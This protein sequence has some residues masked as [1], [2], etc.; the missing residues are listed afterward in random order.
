MLSDKKLL[1]GALSGVLSKISVGIVGF[2][3]IPLALGVLDKEEYGIWMILVSLTSWL[4]LSDFGVLNGIVNFWTT[5]FANKDVNEFQKYLKVGLQVTSGLM[6]LGILLTFLFV[7]NLNFYSIFKIKSLIINNDIRNA[8]YILLY[9]F[10][11]SLPL[12]VVPKIAYSSGN[13][14]IANISTLVSSI[15]SIIIYIYLAKV[16]APLLFWVAASSFSLLLSNILLLLYLIKK[17]PTFF[18]GI[19]L[20]GFNMDLNALKSLLQLSSGF[21]IFQIGGVIVNNAV[22]FII[23][24]KS[25]L[26]FV[27]DFNIIWKIQWFIYSISAAVVYSAFPKIKLYFVKDELTKAVKLFKNSILLQCLVCTVLLAPFFIAGTFIINKWTHSNLIFGINWKG[28]LL[29]LFFLL[30]TSVGSVFSETLKILGHIKIQI[31]AVI[32]NG[33]LLNS[34]IVLLVGKFAMN[35]ILISFFIGTLF[36]TLVFYFYSRKK[37]KV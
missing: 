36:S 26:Q 27:A 37:I 9:V 8:T 35:G 25:N 5:S 15:L 24:Y 23:L 21:F 29:M 32:F 13:N 7:G 4:Q 30:A 20:F 18:T 33:L 16:K 1:L 28:W 3:S 34:L 17:M 2:L 12:S 10:F 11:L 6:L 31:V 19:K 14:Y 22:N